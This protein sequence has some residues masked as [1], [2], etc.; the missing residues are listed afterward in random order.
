MIPPDKG[1]WGVFVEGVVGVGENPFGIVQKL[2]AVAG[3]YF[4]E[5]SE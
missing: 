2:F 3:I 5:Q 1:G 4:S